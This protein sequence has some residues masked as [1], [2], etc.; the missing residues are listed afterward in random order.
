MDKRKNIVL[1]PGGFKESVISNHKE[2]RMI[3]YKRKGFI[4]LALK[5]GY[6][7]CPGYI[8]QE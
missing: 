6:A 4:K 5:Y 8:F 1:Q 2:S 7:I 3:I